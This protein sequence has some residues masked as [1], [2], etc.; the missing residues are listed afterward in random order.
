[1][2]NAQTEVLGAYDLVQEGLSTA[3][4]TADM[5]DPAV[6]ARF[7][8]HERKSNSSGSV[9]FPYGR[10]VFCNDHSSQLG[11][12]FNTVISEKIRRL[13]NTHWLVFNTDPSLN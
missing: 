3:K 7:E 11:V 12:L 13:E 10:N 5:N 2:K 6:R 9:L 8:A 4:K 1:M